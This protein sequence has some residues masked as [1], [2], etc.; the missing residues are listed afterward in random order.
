MKGL[1]ESAYIHKEKKKC[2]SSNKFSICLLNFFNELPVSHRLLGG[3]S[4]QPLEN[5]VFF[6]TESETIKCNELGQTN[7]RFAHHKCGRQTDVALI[8]IPWL[9]ALELKTYYYRVLTGAT[10]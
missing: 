1:R 9:G 5:S 8:Y 4:C 10:G 7:D 6:F 3:L 2:K